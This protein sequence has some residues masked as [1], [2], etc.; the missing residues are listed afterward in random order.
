MSVDCK[1][2]LVRCHFPLE[3]DLWKN[4]VGGFTLLDFKT[5]YKGA[6]IETVWYR[7]QHRNI[8][9]CNSIS[10]VDHTYYNQLNFNKRANGIKCRKEN[11]FNK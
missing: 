4:I 3:I 2:L 8:D 7:H 11:I 9:S 5:H 1:T 10:D 6:A